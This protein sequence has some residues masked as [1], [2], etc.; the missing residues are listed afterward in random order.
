MPLA[1]GGALFIAALGVTG[2][3][4]NP[5]FIQ[6]RGHITVADRAAAGMAQGIAALHQSMADRYPLVEN[7]AFTL[8][9]A[10][11][12]WDFLQ[13]AQNAALEVID[14]F[15]PFGLQE[16]GGFF[17]ADTTG[18]EHRH[19][20]RFARAQQPFPLPPEPC[21]KFGEAAGLRINGTGK[22]AHGHL[23]IIARI[24]DDGVRVRDKAFQSCGST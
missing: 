4:T 2:G 23:V 21:G 11:L 1:I 12:L 14:V 15:H 18:A 6:G 13:I 5:V 10:L 8:P 20:R 9:Q 19:F 24:D 7:E 16:S 17:A 22:T 3:A